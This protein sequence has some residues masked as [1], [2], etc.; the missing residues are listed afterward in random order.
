M[1]S[2]LL[3]VGLDSVNWEALQPQLNA[4]R[5]PN[6]ASLLNGSA[7][8]VLHS[9]VPAH[10]AAAWTTFTTG[11]SPGQHGILHFHRFDPRTMTRRLNTTYDLH[12]KTIWQLLD[13]RGF[14]AGV[15]GQPQSYP[16]RE[17]KHGFAMSGFETPGTRAKF[18]WPLSLKTEI[19][20]HAPEF[21]FKNERADGHSIPSLFKE[22]SDFLDGVA[23]IQRDL[24]ATHRVNLYL[25]KSHPWDVLFL[26]YQQP[27]ILFHKAW[28]WCDPATRDEDPERARI[29]DA[30]FV[31]L[32]EMIGEILSLPQSSGALTLICSDHG[33]GPLHEKVRVN[34]LLA[35]QGFLRRG[36]VLN[37]ARNLLS[38]VSRH[39]TTLG[40]P[41]DWPRT[42]AYMAFDAKTGFIFMNRKGREPAGIVDGADLDAQIDELIARMKAVTSP[43]SGRPIFD[44]LRALKSEFPERGPYDL[45]D[46]FALPAPG[47]SFTRKISRKPAV[48]KAKVDFEGTHRPEGFF[49]LSGPDV[50][51]VRRDVQMLDVAP[52]LLAALELPVPAD[53]SGAVRSDLFSRPPTVTRGPS[54]A[55]NI[56][57]AGGVYTESERAV[58]E[59]RLKDL[60]YE[61]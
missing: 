10:T 33:H 24:E 34:G 23:G 57:D 41:L 2:K 18:T 52:T 7:K 61:D 39:D 42:R 22:K 11:K 12:H 3:V 58:V 31:R 60:G 20:A 55:L 44:D 30:F 19:L 16:L 35:E 32:D 4:A 53:M 46:I 59:Q 25:A 38:R 37:R 21:S 8:G 40:L 15:V 13:E 50:A 48:A 43:L 29:I 45:P 49:I 9:T 47:V 27:D 56:E 54:S 26:Y 28:R 6:L 17:L 1:P 51:P 5:M 14:R 36:G